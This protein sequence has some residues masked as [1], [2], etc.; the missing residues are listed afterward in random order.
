ML[1]RPDRWSPDGDWVTPRQ[2]SR[3]P[4]RTRFCGWDAGVEHALL[5][6]SEPLRDAVRGA[7][8]ILGR[9]LPAPLA[10]VARLV[11]VRV[12]GLPADQM[13]EVPFE[14]NR[15]RAAEPLL[16]AW[17]PPSRTLGGFH[18]LRP[19]GAGAVGSV[20]VACRA[21]ERGRKHPQLFALKVPDYGGDVAHTLS[22]AEFLQLFREEAG[23]LLAVPPHPNLARLVTFDAGV[24]PKPILVMELVEGPTLERLIL[25]RVLEAGRAMR[26]LDGVAAAL[27]AMHATGVGHL[28]IKPSNIILRAPDETVPLSV[29][30]D[31]SVIVPRVFADFRCAGWWRCAGAWWTLVLRAARFDRVAR[32]PFMAR[33]RSG[34][35]RPKATNLVPWPLTSTLSPA[36]PSRC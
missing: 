18:L 34:A 11:L 33:P 32:P 24:K 20:F 5:G 10:E 4:A 36:S 13:Q 35:R 25:T 22:E 26:I 27:E 8:E 7:V 12:Q 17:V 6:D 2:P 16:P 29:D 14:L 30:L 1:A 23:A 9:E 15:P 3:H 28:D 21:E 19:L 31:S